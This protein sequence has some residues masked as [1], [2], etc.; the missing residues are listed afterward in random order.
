MTQ[1]LLTSDGHL[2]VEDVS[3]SVQGYQHDAGATQEHGGA[4]DAAHSLAQPAL[5]TNQYTYEAQVCFL[6]LIIGPSNA[7]LTDLIDTNS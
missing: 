6:H 2:G 1:G 3:V 5:Q 4:L 7:S